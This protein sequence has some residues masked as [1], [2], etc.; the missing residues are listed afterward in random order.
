MSQ[1]YTEKYLKY[2]NKY[3]NLKKLYINKKQILGGMNRQNIDT[4]ENLT[5]TPSQTEVYGRKLKVSNFLS[6]QLGGGKF[7]ESNISETELSLSSLN[8]DSDV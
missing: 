5:A 2:K 6:N 1:D 4:L 7:S 8:T 3:L